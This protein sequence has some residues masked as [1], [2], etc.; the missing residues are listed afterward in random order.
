[1]KALS[2]RRG[3][4]HV[5][6][7]LGLVHITVGRKDLEGRRVDAIEVIPGK[8]FGGVKVIRR[9]AEIIRLI[10]L[11]T[12]GPSSGVRSAKYLDLPASVSPIPSGGAQRKVARIGDKRK[13]ATCSICGASVRA[14][15]LARHQG[16]V[17]PN[18]PAP[19][20]KSVT[21]TW[22][23][24]RP[25]KRKSGRKVPRSGDLLDIALR[26]GAFDTNRRRH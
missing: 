14:D 8:G 18:P 17:H 13:R 24:P 15:R 6:T 3:V 16:R 26:G 25:P 7:P 21:A 11:K 20:P 9:G 2:H 5:E 19:G 1:M 4:L 22:P 23:V 10:E 12:T